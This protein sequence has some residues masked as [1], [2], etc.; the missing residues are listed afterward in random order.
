MVV[1]RI[2]EG[3][4]LLTFGRFTECPTELLENSL[5]DKKRPPSAVV[6]L[7][8]ST[9]PA[10]FHGVNAVINGLDG[11]IPLIL[12]AARQN[13]PTA[14]AVEVLERFFELEGEEA[15]VI[16]LEGKVDELKPEELEKLVKNL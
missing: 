15:K 4:Y 16:P 12:I 10:T 3:Y 5:K 6:I 8:D 1:K 11:E 13:L 9:D 7:F 14:W 2:T